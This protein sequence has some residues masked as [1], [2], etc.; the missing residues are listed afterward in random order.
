[1][2]LEFSFLGIILEKRRHVKY[3][4]RTGGGVL[5]YPYLYL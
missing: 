4:D 1:M 2:S 5:F 3:I